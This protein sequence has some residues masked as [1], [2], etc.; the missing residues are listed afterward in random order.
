MSTATG[1]AS[2]SKI[3][4]LAPPDPLRFQ[5][6]VLDERGFFDIFWQIWLSRL[7]DWLVKNIVRGERTGL[8]D[9]TLTELVDIALT[10]GTYA[11]GVISG[12][13]MVT[14]GTDYQA[15]QFGFGFAAVNK[16]GTITTDLQDIQ[17]NSPRAASAGG[18][19]LTP[20]PDLV[21][22]TNKITF[23][24]AVDTA[25]VNPTIAVS[26]EVKSYGGTQ[27]TV[28]GQS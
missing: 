20:A 4:M 1:K 8:T 22:G 17:A 19:A 2:Y 24:L 25:L 21:N 18:I 15:F 6:K 28:I 5:S 7:R 14:D 23:R 27:I 10:P 11:G 3:N 13:A 26:F 16:A 9:A 12:V